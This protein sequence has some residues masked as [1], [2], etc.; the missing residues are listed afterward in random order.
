MRLAWIVALVGCGPPAAARVAPPAEERR[1]PVEVTVQEVPAEDRWRLEYRLAE[2]AM[3]IRFVANRNRYRREKWAPGAGLHWEEQES[4]EE[5]RAHAPTDRFEVDFPTLTDPLPKDYELNIPFSDGS[6]LLY[7]GHLIAVPVDAEGQLREPQAAV[8]GHRFLFRTAAERSIR[9]L[10]DA[11][12]E[13]LTWDQ[14]QPDGRGTY[15]YFGNIEPLTGAGFSAIVDPGMPPWMV[16]STKAFIPEL[17]AF[18]ADAVKVDLT[19]EP[20][21]L[22]SWGGADRP[23]RSSGGGSLAGLLQLSASGSGFA[24]ASDPARVHWQHF[25]AHEVFHLW[26]AQARRTRD[27]SEEEWISEGSAEYFAERALLSAGTL[28]AAT[29]RRRAVEKAN[30]CLAE[31]DGAPLLGH[32]APRFGAFYPCGWALMAAADGYE[33][34]LGRVL[35]RTFGGDDG[36]YGTRDFLAALAEV[37]AERSAGI[38]TFLYRGVPKHADRAFAALLPGAEVVPVD[39]ATM[40]VYLSMKLLARQ[41]VR[42]DCEHAPRVA[43][44][45]GH[46]VV[47]PGES[48]AVLGDGMAITHVAGFAV[49][50]EALR[51]YAALLRGGTIELQPEAALRCPADRLPR[52]YTKLLRAP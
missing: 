2:P 47:A 45:D 34:A 38:D 25:L 10:E 16:K 44:S 19:F 40:D 3:G 4:H 9:V 24:E 18:Y 12:A 13:E 35:A 30:Q 23:G 7:T 31:L 33:R 41:L 20:L 11:A 32:E 22:L 21:L 52:S 39:E 15:A 1:P 17:F 8:A 50:D 43:L 48:C 46:I 49:T 51:A 26:N 42:C 29:L 37:D 5:L 36:R 27:A 14:A 6:R 28:D